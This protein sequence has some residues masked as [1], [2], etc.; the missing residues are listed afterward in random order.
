MHTS[1]EFRILGLEF[2]DPTLVRIRQCPL[3]ER[4]AGDRVQQPHNI[5]VPCLLLGR[6]AVVGEGRES[7]VACVLAH[8]IASAWGGRFGVEVA[9]GWCLYLM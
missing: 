4:R 6:R 7:Q 9:R 5:L 2:A 8:R 3:L 1:H